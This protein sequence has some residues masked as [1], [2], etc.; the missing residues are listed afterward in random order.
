[1]GSSCGEV[2]GVPPTLED[3]DL[4]WLGQQG[5]LEA[6]EVVFALEEAA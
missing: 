2:L 6:G 1:M 3:T 4:W 5:E